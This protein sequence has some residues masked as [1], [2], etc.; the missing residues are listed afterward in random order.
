MSSPEQHTGHERKVAPIDT[1]EHSRELQKSLERDRPTVESS[2]ERAHEARLKASHEALSSK[3]RKET[4]P[5]ESE[6]T[7][8]IMASRARLAESFDKTMQ[9][10][11]AQMSLPART[12]SKIIHS[13]A[14]EKTSDFVGSTVARPDAILSGSVS[15][16]LLTLAVYVIARY[17]GF[18]L[19]GSVTIIAFIIGW[20][21]GVVF[22]MLRAVFRSRRR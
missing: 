18:E 10:T 6:A 11:R 19:S 17:I 7:K 3:Q 4:K 20:L 1:T 15:A 12:F 21:L 22:D 5:H 16:L 8:P 14:V 2:S 13:P 9:H